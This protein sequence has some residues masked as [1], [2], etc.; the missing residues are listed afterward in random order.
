VLGGL[1]AGLVALLYLTMTLLAPIPPLAPELAEPAPVE[2]DLAELDWP[3]YGAGAIGVVEL[4]EVL[5]LRGSEEAL[6]MASITKLVTVLTVLDRHPLGLGE[7]GPEIAMGPADLEWYRHYLS[8][9]GKVL[10]V[11]SGQRYSQED[12]LELTLIES[13]NNH[14]ASL[15]VWAFGSEQAFLDAARAW[16]DAHG[17]TTL[18]VV[19]P[20]GIDRRNVGSAAELLRLGEAALSVPIV[21]ELVARS[22]SRVEHV[23]A[24]DST[25]TLLGRSGVNG[26]KTGT[27][28]GFGANLLFSAAVDVDGAPVTVVGAVLG[29]PDHA[30]LARDVRALL[31]TA[32]ERLALR[33]LVARG[34]VLGSYTTSWGGEADLVAAEDATALIWGDREFVARVEAEE[35]ILAAAGARVGRLVLESG[36]ETIEIPVE[37]SAAIEDPGP[38]WRLTHPGLIFGQP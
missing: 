1:G 38:W 4:P 20:A 29:A 8:L 13:S 2:I 11:S 21:A 24:I 32:D 22:E 28:D 10:P 35:V 27:L 9:N 33:T 3:G 30:T 5:E 16:L 17:F 34:D 23:G 14:A 12:L 15:A 37:L 31:A 19:D 26:I 6:P 25:N 36:Q 7:E 18:R